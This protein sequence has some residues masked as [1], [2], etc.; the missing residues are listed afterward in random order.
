[1]FHPHDVNLTDSVE[2]HEVEEKMDKQL[3]NSPKSLTYY[4]DFMININMES[5]K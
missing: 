2:A 5:F 4:E 1:M 3:Q